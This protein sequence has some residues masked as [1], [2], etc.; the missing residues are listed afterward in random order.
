MKRNKFWAALSK[1]LAAVTLVATLVLV[2]GAWAQSTY[3]VLHRFTGTDGNSP[4]A[5]LIFDQS[6]N[7]YGTTRY[8]G[9]N[10]SG[11]VFELIPNQDGSWTESVVHSF[12]GSYD[13][14]RPFATLIFDQAGSLYGTTQYGGAKRGGIVFEL[15]PS[16]GGS[17]KESILYNFSDGNYGGEPLD[18]VVLDQTGNLYGTTTSGGNLGG[19]SATGC[20]VVFKLTPMPGGSWKETKL[21]R[22]TGGKD[23]GVPYAGLIFDQAGNLYGTTTS[24]GNLSYCNGTG[25]GVVFK[26]TPMPGGSWKETALHQFTGG[27]DGASPYASLIFDQSGNLYG[28]TTS[29]GNLSYCNGTG[30]GVVF[31]LTPMP[32]GSWKETAL[33]RFTGGKDGASPYARLI[34]DSAG[35]VYG[36]TWGGGAGGYGVVFKL[37]LGSD[38]KW[39]EH[40]LHAFAASG[41]HPHAGLILD[42]AGNLYGTTEGDGSTTFGLVFEVTP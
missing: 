20:G 28:T 17:W 15:T 32:D 29:G 30:C 23:G 42:A 26:L 2:S 14:Y 36:T 8:G 4:S 18:S 6:G 35:N 16:A 39:R 11:V 27:K 21:H 1:T 33:H 5:G 31:K 40:V 38:G 34:F 22:F 24:R 10:G 9:G 7:L 12:T 19:C 13:G 25:C 41:A 37:T 3:K